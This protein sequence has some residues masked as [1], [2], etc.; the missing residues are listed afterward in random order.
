MEPPPDGLVAHSLL[1]RLSRA[2]QNWHLAQW[3]NVLFSDEVRICLHH[4]DGYHRVWRRPGKG[5]HEQ[6]V[7]PKTAYG[8][9][10]IMVLAGI[11][12]TVRTQLVRINGNLNA[13]Y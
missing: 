2:H 5:H 3:R 9:S 13:H 1:T 8:V 10:S 6:C 7:Q 4:V 11:S 12:V